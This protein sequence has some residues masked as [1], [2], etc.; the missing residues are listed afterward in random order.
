MARVPVGVLA[1]PGDRISARMSR[2]AR[3]YRE[4]RL[5]GRAAGLL[6]SA[7]APSWAFA[8]LPMSQSSSTAIRAAGTWDVG[9]VK[10]VSKGK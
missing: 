7:K 1:R 6:G 4:H 9:T 2:A 10:N 3:I 8:N 5:I